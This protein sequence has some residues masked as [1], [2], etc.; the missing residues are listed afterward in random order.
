VDQDYL[1]KT[2]EQL[3]AQE[4]EYIR[5]RYPSSQVYK[6][7]GLTRDTLR[8]YEALG[9]LSPNKNEDNNYREY[10]VDDI[11]N[12]LAIDFYRKRGITPKELT[13]IKSEHKPEKY[14]QLFVDKKAE[15]VEYIRY[16][17]RVMAKLDETIA[18]METIEQELNQITVRE[19]P[20]Y[21]IYE[22]ISSYTDIKAYK[23]KVLKHIDISEDDIVSNLFKTVWFDDKGYLDTK[24]YLVKPVQ[25]KIP[26]KSYLDHGEAMYM[27]VEG[28]ITDRDDQMM[29]LFVECMEWA[30]QH[31]RKFRGVV[32]M[33]VKCIRWSDKGMRNYVELWAPLSK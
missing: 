30:R 20:V 26:G 24:S 18:F 8:Y 15:L 27:A 23:E 13:Q 17:Q 28:Q 25:E 21:E 3:E 1:R 6:G 32:Y 11:I 7:L 29:S 10:S 14:R 22:E 5:Q 4:L 2:T 9:I 12:I 16:Q 31:Q 19:F 33:K